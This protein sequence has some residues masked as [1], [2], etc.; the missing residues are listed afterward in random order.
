MKNY[1]IS[2]ILGGILLFIITFIISSCSSCTYQNGKIDQAEDYAENKIILRYYLSDDYD[3]AA[4]GFKY[5][6]KGNTFVIDAKPVKEGYRFMGWYDSPNIN[7]ARQYADAN[8]YSLQSI[9][10]DILLYPL[11]IEE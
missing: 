4:V 7:I 9:Q 8:G 5:V 2:G 3:N 1:Y 6:V 11:F 10:N